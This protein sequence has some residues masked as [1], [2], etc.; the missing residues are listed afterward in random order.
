M[1]WSEGHIWFAELPYSDI[2]APFEFKFVIK[3][4]GK[5]SRWEKGSNHGF[6]LQKYT[7]MLNNPILLSKIEEGNYDVVELA[8]D[9]EIVGFNRKTKVMHVQAYWQ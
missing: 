3:E 7:L 6:D 4:Q 8:T 9:N 5:V 1:T 2:Q